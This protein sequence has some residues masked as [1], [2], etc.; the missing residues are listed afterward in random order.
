MKQPA[1]VDLP[2]AWRQVPYRQDVYFVGEDLEGGYMRMQ[3]RLYPGQPGDPKLDLAQVYETP[4][5][6]L[7]LVS[8]ERDANGVP[9]SRVQIII[10][11]AT[12]IDLPAVDPQAEIGN[13]DRFAYDFHIAAAGD[14]K[15][16]AMVGW[17]TVNQGVTYFA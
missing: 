16:V 15:T 3:L 14:F 13:P 5:E 7:Y 17:L 11:V 1:K 2:P 9:T 6:G 8:V 4:V 10:N 12:L